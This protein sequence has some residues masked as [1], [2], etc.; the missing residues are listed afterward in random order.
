M[1]WQQRLAEEIRWRRIAQLQT[2]LADQ[3]PREHLRF[4]AV[5]TQASRLQQHLKKGQGA[6][7]GRARPPASR[8]SQ[9]V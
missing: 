2:L 3:P 4:R 6:A 1:K 5:A 8:R 7:S 9:L